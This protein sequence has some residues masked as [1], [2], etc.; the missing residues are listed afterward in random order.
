MTGDLA[1]T[2]K[3]TSPRQTF[4]ILQPRWVSV[5]LGKGQGDRSPSGWID[6]EMV[7]KMVEGCRLK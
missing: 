5:S 4:S 1:F 6:V 7:V 3:A 2:W